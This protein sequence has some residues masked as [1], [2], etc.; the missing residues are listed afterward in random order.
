MRIAVRIT[1]LGP[2]HEQATPSG[3]A[4]RPKI[5]NDVPGERN[6]LT[7]WEINGTPEQSQRHRPPRI[8]T[9]LCV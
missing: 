8:P 6:D 2:R 9:S 5:E 3:A 7:N 1:R 4:R